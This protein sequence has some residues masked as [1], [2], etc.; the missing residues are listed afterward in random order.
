MPK[1]A[2]IIG[3]GPAGLTAAYELLKNTD[4]KP[5][6]FEQTGDI[7][8]I[9]KTVN[10]KGNRIDIG[11]HRF[12]SKS[13]TIMQWWKEILPQ[14]A[15]TCEEAENYKLDCML[16]RNRKSRILY[17]GKFFNYPVSL[18]KQTILNLGIWNII[19]IG[20]SYIKAKIFPRKEVSLEDFFIN[21]FGKELYGTF[22]ENYTEKVWGVPCG[23]INAE[24]GSQRVKGLSILSVFKD[25]IKSVFNGN[26]NND[27][28]QK[29]VETSLITQFLYPPHGP[30]QL[31]EKT[32]KLI[33]EKGGEIHLNKKVAELYSANDHITKIKVAD[34]LNSKENFAE[35]DYFISTMPIKDLAAAWRGSIP[36]DI[37]KI[38]SGLQYRDF[39]TVGL[40]LKN[41]D[42]KAAKGK[43]VKDNWI[44]IQEPHV[45][46]GRLQIFNN[47]SP[48]MVKDPESTWIGLEY[49]CY[50]NDYIWNM[51]ESAM[52]NFAINEL[53][54]I[55]I[56]HKKD[57]LDSIV[58]KMQKT[59][60]AYFG[61]YE[62]IGVIKEFVSQ[63]GNLFLIGRNG[64]HRYNNMD[65]SMLTAMEAVKNIANGI[66]IKD[67]IWEVNAEKEYHES[68]NN[69]L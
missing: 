67:N 60:P 65:H 68:K 11:G 8:G 38:A 51:K 52:I 23:K 13:D 50:E 63:F 55:N 57:V 61:T 59:Y 3:A 31:W 53:E 44:Y 10:Y 48:F 42:I 15:K 18:N 9:A 33:K 64:M 20:F 19:K 56:I 2:I 4:V 39:V 1:T 22:F 24:W 41:L 47:W 34:T 28:S 46:I 25:A 54:K 32:A 17:S 58:I 40:L 36:N 29:N 27:I 7:G 14:H 30:G 26:K 62:R 66:K 21:R 49:F 69:Q 16:L 6:I 12:F 45:K 43:K 37:K 5:I 35:G